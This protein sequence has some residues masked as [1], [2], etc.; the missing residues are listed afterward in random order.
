[1]GKRMGSLLLAVVLAALATA[2]LI[3]YVHALENK[4]FTGVETVEV[5]VAK[6]SIPA[7]MSAD[8]AVQRAAITTTT[9]PRKVVAEGAI[10]SLDEI[11]GKV[12]AVTIVPGEQIVSSRF[13]ELSA[14]GS[15]LEIP[16]GRQAMA[17]ELALPPGVGGYIQPGARVSVIAHLSVTSGRGADARAQYL[18]QDVSVLAVGQKVV[19]AA[20]EG[21]RGAARQASAAQ[22]RTLLTL[23]VTPSEAEKLA[24][25]IFEGDVYFTLLPPDQKPV[26]TSGRNGASVFR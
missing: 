24:F 20:N 9:V 17:V 6:D 5:F 16:A 8:A 3:S 11:R 25:A 4:A 14:V 2:A 7:G 19:S 13:V 10:A 15:G 18:L 26:R 22:D 23:A 12:A 21:S 1:M